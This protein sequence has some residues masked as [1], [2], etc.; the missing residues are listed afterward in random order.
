MT[1]I[2]F[3]TIVMNRLN[4]LKE[5]LPQNLYD[6]KD[7][8][9]LEVLLLDYNSDDGLG[10]YIYENYRQ[11]ID[12]RRLVYFRSEISKYFNRSHSRN[13]AFKLASGT[14]LCNI[15]ADNYA[16][17]GFASYVRKNF[18]D[19]KDI[20]LSTID[21][22]RVGSKDCLGR[23]CVLKDDFLKVGGFD[24]RMS[25][26]G[27]EDYDLVYRLIMSGLKNVVIKDKVFL[28][29]IEHPNVERIKNESLSNFFNEL[30]IKYID[31]SHSELL[32]I[33]DGLCAQSAIIRNNRTLNSTSIL[34]RLSQEFEISIVGNEWVIYKILVGN[35]CFNLMSTSNIIRRFDVKQNGNLIEFDKDVFYKIEFPELIEES[36]LFHSE[37]TNRIIMEDNLCNKRICVNM[38][39]FGKDRVFKNFDRTNPIVI[40]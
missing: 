7:C 22:V 34:N 2:S 25:S 31:T 17:K 37:I 8:P 12:S 27:F 39:G 36:L 32:I 38:E 6:N 10:D 1:K 4:H 5:T 28:R 11:E 24:E 3:C 40:V 16:G 19:Y 33:S 26:Y 18:N 20:L 29:A 35:N 23:I 15:D 13:L 9:D 14:I 30:Y 21:D